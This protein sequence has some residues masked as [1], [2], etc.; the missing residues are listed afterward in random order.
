MA[1]TAKAEVKQRKEEL[2]RIIDKKIKDVKF[3]RI[4]E[5]FH[6][7]TIRNK[8][9]IVEDDLLRGNEANLKYQSRGSPIDGELDGV[10]FCCTL[11]DEDLP[12]R[13]P[14]G[15]RRIRIPVEHFLRG[16]PC[17]YFNSYH[18][19][20]GRN[21]PVH[22][23]TL[24]LVDRNDPDF[25]FCNK[26]LVR[27]NQRQNPFLRLRKERSGYTLFRCFSN[28]E[29][30]RRFKLYVDVFVVGNVE[31]PESAIWDRVKYKGRSRS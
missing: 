28:Q 25:S 22:Y 27:L 11:F 15:S 13:S 21:G 23:V 19:T 5:F 7:T 16:N 1:R 29:C 4:K 2:E 10:F 6:V 20:D 18:V 24:V 31:L 3:D 12:T 14:Y 26:N 8:S 30:R 9:K 17:L